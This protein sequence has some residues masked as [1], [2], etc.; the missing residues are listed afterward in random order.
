MT[1]AIQA[2]GAVMALIGVALVSSPEKYMQYFA[3]NQVSLSSTY[4]G[5]IGLG[6]I[7]LGLYLIVK[8][9]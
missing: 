3:F 1:R 6:L 9:R 7:G 2:V 5:W 4:I 8:K